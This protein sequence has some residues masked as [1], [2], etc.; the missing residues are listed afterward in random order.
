ML[1]K[2][3]FPFHLMEPRP[4]PRRTSTGFGVIG[5]VDFIILYFGTTATAATTTTGF[6]Y[7]CLE[8]F[9]YQCVS[10]GCSSVSQ[11]QGA[12]PCQPI[13]GAQK[14]KEPCQSIKGAQKKKEDDVMGRSS[15]LCVV[16]PVPPSTPPGSCCEAL[17]RCPRA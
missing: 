13:K 5:P 12:T 3:I 4:L 15:V 8:F 14:K 6:F 11:G 9:F 17:N 10:V 16:L 2:A 7:S 1:A